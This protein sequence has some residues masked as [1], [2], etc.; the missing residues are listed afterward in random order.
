MCFGMH[1][2]VKSPLNSVCEKEQ[3]SLNANCKTASASCGVVQ[4]FLRRQN[5]LFK[6]Q[7]PWMSLSPTRGKVPDLCL[8]NATHLQF[9]AVSLGPNSW[10]KGRNKMVDTIQWWKE[11][12][13]IATLPAAFLALEFPMMLCG[14]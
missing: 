12:H 2:V 1:K 3:A 13:L 4:N 7:S 11:F 14:Y 9:N 5:C 10:H 8:L 6:T